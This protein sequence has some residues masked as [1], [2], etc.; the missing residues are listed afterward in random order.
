MFNNNKT[1]CPQCKQIPCACD[2]LQNLDYPI[3]KIDAKKIKEKIE[4]S[5]D[6]LVINVLNK[7]FYDDCHIKESINI[8]FSESEKKAQGWDKTKEII[9]YCASSLCTAS[10][11]AFKILKKMGF[12][13]VYAYEGGIKDWTKKGFETKGPC[14]IEY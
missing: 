5:K 8:P 9:V 13:H 14:L 12:E 6:I 3:I 2:T 4:K 7:E 10:N 11:A 1:V